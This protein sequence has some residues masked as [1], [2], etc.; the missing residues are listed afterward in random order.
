MSLTIPRELQEA[1]LHFGL[2]APA[3][4]AI[5]MGEIDGMSLAQVDEMR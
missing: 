4:I 1:F 5:E 2:P 3:Q